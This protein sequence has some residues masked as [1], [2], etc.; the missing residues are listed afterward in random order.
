MYRC[1][2][3]GELPQMKNII[4][5]PK[6]RSVLNVEG[7]EEFGTTSLSVVKN[8]SFKLVQVLK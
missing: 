6:T 4:S 3:L 7:I 1:F 8:C 2:Y 5:T